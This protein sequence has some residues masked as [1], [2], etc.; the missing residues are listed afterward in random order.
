MYAATS[1]EIFMLGVVWND[2]LRRG[3]EMGRAN[4]LL[5]RCILTICASHLGYTVDVVSLLL[6]Y[7]EPYL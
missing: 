1:D 6:Y 3:W 4:I 7:H 2:E 5:P